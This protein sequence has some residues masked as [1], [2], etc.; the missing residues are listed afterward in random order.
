[1]TTRASQTQVT[2]HTLGLHGIVTPPLHPRCCCNRLIKCQTGPFVI[3]IHSAVRRPRD[4]IV[5]YVL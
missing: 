2:S 5:S 3:V 1:M 4:G